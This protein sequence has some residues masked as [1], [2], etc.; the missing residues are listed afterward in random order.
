M[1]QTFQNGKSGGI[2]TLV[3]NHFK[4]KGCGTDVDEANTDR[5]DGQSCYNNK[6]V[7][8]ARALAAWL[9]TDPT[10]SGDPDVLIVGDL[11]AYAKEDPIRLL[12]EEG[13]RYLGEGSAEIPHFSFSYANQR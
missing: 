2:F 11:N 10:K 7:E 9:K 5:G 1:A 3:V 4:S 8:A 13:F 12:Q 6:R